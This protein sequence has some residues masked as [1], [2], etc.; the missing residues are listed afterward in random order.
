MNLELKIPPVILVAIFCILMYQVYVLVPVLRFDYSYSKVFSISLCS[1]GV[2]IIVSG[3]ISFRREKTTVNPLR[4][5]E[6]S[7]LVTR[8]VYRLTRNPMYLGMAVILFAWAVY[9]SSFFSFVIAGLFIPYMNQYQIKPEERFLIELFG[10]SYYE[11]K[12][13][14]RCWL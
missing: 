7:A 4:P 6:A 13:R 14:V 3:V 12:S 2:F 9:L 5:G 1:L 8:G 10:D 11:Y